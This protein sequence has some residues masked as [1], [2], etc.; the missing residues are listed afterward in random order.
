[1]YKY[2]RIIYSESRIKQLSDIVVE[3]ISTGVYIVVKDRKEQ[4][5]EN[6]MN[7]KILVNLLNS[8]NKVSVSPLVSTSGNI[9]Y[10]NFNFSHEDIVHQN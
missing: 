6:Y 8:K 2:S 9:V 10:S 3:E 5:D 1:M 4:T 7:S